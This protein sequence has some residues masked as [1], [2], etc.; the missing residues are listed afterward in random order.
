MIKDIL[1]ILF[2]SALLV[3]LLYAL[4][5]YVKPRRSQADFIIGLLNKLSEP[6]HQEDKGICPTKKEF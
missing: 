3:V 2:A 5:R 6:D 4:L 1:Q